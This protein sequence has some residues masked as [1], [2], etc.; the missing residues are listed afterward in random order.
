VKEAGHEADAIALS[1]N[2]T[3]ATVLRSIAPGEIVR[4]RCA[5]ALHEVTARGPIPLCHKISVRPHTPGALVRKYGE[6][7]GEATQPIE[8]GAHVHVHNMRSRRGRP[9]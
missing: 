4:V 2:D 3:V 9:V 8:V 7:I 1:L 5:G 6:A